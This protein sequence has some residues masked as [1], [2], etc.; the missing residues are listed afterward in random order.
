MNYQFDDNSKINI[1]NNANELID[2]KNVV[3]R[4]NENSNVETPTVIN[5][6]RGH[7]INSSK[8][9]NHFI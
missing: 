3:Q 9:S 5:T 1:T 4:K 7:M 6:N 2:K 8:T